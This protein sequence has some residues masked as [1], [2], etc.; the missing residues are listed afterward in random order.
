MGTL[1]MLKCAAAQHTKHH[2]AERGMEY[3]SQGL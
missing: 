1:T 2:I 3:V